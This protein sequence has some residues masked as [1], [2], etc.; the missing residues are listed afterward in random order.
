PEALI[1]TAL[2]IGEIDAAARGLFRSVLAVGILA[3]GIA[4]L[5]ATAVARRLARPIEELTRATTRIGRGDLTTPIPR[6]VEAVELAELAGSM[7]EMRGRLLDLTAESRR[8]RK[9]AEAI[10]GGI[11]EG[12][13]AV[14]RERRV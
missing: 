2:P 12:V 7:E 5:L 11:S 3:G 1:E 4:A 13:Y 10:L 14:D 8:R 9:D 6:P